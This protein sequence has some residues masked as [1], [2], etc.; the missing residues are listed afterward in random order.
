MTGIENPARE[1]GAY[2]I[3]LKDG[4]YITAQWDAARGR[5]QFE[6]NDDVLTPEELA[7]LGHRVLIRREGDEGVEDLIRRYRDTG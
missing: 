1:S 6:D 5:W 2:W 4:H 3:E 7:G